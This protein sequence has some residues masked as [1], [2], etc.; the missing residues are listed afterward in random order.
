VFA[1]LKLWVETFK[2]DFPMVL[3]P[4]YQLGNYAT[5]ETAPLNPPDRRAHH[6]DHREVRG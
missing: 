1:D 3:D 2:V 5:A 6:A 4:D